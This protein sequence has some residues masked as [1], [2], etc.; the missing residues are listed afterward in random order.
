M[1]RGEVHALA[2]ALREVMKTQLAGIT[3]RVDE[4]ESSVETLLTRSAPPSRL[5]A[6]PEQRDDDALDELRVLLKRSAERAEAIEARLAEIERRTLADSYK[7]I[8]DADE[9]FARG[10]LVT[11]GGSLWIALQDVSGYKPGSDNGSAR[12]WQLVVKRGKDV[13]DAARP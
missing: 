3:A 6:A 9:T 11:H 8:W 10:D 5:G 13:R 12:V 7:G 2:D 1:K 4:V